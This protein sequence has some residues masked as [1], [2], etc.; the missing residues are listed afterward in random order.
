MLLLALTDQFDEA[1]GAHKAA[2]DVLVGLTS[3]YDRAYYAGIIAERRAKAQF[4]RAGA[5]ASARRLR[6]ADR[7]HAALRARRG[8]A[9]AWQ[10]RRAAALERVRAV[11]PAASA[12]AAS[13]DDRRKS[14]CW[15]RPA[16]RLWS[17]AFQAPRA[18]ASS[19]P[20]PLRRGLQP[21]I[22]RREPAQDIAPRAEARNPPVERGLQAANGGSTLTL[23]DAGDTLR[24]APSLRSTP[25]HCAC[26]PEEIR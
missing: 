18:A 17:G 10:R 11:H 19:P 4:A 23:P 9:P 16:I 5:A 15:N 3:D 22:R 12:A 6:L 2:R 14:R 13:V 25:R 20:R 26:G 21:P 8:P 1:A 24:C 7:G